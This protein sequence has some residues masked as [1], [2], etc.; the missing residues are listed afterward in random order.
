MNSDLS[1]LNC[2]FTE[3]SDRVSSQLQVVKTAKL[4]FEELKIFMFESS[5]FRICQKAQKR[6]SPP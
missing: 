2:S 5:R 1:K 4:R 3:N 6:V